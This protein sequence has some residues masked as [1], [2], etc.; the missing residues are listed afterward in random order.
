VGR[1]IFG[2]LIRSSLL[3][4][5]LTGL[6]DLHVV[7][8]V[9]S[10]RQELVTIIL[11]LGNFTNHPIFAVNAQCL[12]LSG[13]VDCV[14]I[15]LLFVMASSNKQRG[16]K[17]HH[18]EDSWPEVIAGYLEFETPFKHAGWFEYVHR[19]TN[20]YHSGVA[21]SF[22]QSFNGT[23]VIVGDL[24]FEVTEQSIANACGLPMDGEH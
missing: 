10:T 22:A 13:M 8:I 3:N 19:I 6:D 21:L 16:G 2:H 7:N 24:N 15:F 18:R 23:I 4:R 20:S 5:V 1:Q 17:L 12:T 14:L 11:T 9:F